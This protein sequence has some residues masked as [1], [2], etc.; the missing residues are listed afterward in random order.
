MDVRP[1][2]GVMPFGFPLGFQVR[3]FSGARVF[4]RARGNHFGEVDV[5]A[6][7]GSLSHPKLGL[8]LG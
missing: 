4:R 1:V 8:V 7:T 2:K 3:R 6:D 5:R